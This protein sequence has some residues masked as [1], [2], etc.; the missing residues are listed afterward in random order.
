M[1]KV[2]VSPCAKSPSVHCTL[3]PLIFDPSLSH[4]EVEI[5]VKPFG[6]VSLTSVFFASAKPL[7][8][9]VIVYVTCSP[10]L[11][12]FGLTVFVI[13]KSAPLTV[14]DAVLLFVVAVSLSAVSFVTVA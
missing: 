11:A 7:F 5:F 2:F 8:E 4:P 6:N 14:T 3:L 10:N 9:T 13:F 1:V 12:G